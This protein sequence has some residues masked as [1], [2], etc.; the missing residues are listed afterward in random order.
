MAARR[1]LQLFGVI[2]G[3]CRVV[4]YVEPDSDKLLSSNT[5]RTQLLS[6]GEPLP[7]ADWAAEFRDGM[8]DELKAHM[9]EITRGSSA[10]DHKDAIRER[11]RQIR[12]LLRLSRYRPTKTGDLQVVGDTVGGKSDETGRTRADKSSKP[13]GRGGRAGGIYALFVA[14]DGTPGEQVRTE[15]EPERYGSPSRMARGLQTS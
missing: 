9:E 3:H 10:H 6:D 14:E 11:L 15:T 8:P 5:A 1:A 12:D 7:W 13:G 4:I 2:F